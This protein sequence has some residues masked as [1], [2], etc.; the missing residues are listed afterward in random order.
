MHLI[1]FASHHAE[2]VNRNRPHVSITYSLTDIT[3][4][5]HIHTITTPGRYS[6]K[7]HSGGILPIFVRRSTSF[8]IRHTATVTITVTVTL[9]WCMSTPLRR[10]F[11]RKLDLWLSSASS[12]GWLPPSLERYGDELRGY[13]LIRNSKYA[14]KRHEGFY[15]KFD[16]RLSVRSRLA[17]WMDN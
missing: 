5:L 12:Y 2:G 11:R 6:C 10:L 16:S 3:T 14:T 17:A 15:V 4:Y 9:P 7:R 1:I 8:L 13:M